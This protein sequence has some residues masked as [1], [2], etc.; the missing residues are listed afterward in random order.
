MKVKFLL[1]LYFVAC[2]YLYSQENIFTISERIGS[3][4]DSTTRVY[5]GLFSKVK[6]FKKA[7]LEKQNEQLRFVIECDSSGK[8][9]TEY[10][11][12]DSQLLDDYKYWVENFETISQV[13]YKD[14]HNYDTNY[15]KNC[16]VT[17]YYINKEKNID[18]ILMD[19]SK[20]HGQLIYSD[21]N[22]V[23]IYKTNELYNWRQ[24]DKLAVCIYY[25]DILKINDLSYDLIGG[26][27]DIF[28]KNRYELNDYVSYTGEISYLH[29]LSPESKNLLK[30]SMEIVK[31]KKFYE[32]LGTFEI[33]EYYQLKMSEKRSLEQISFLT[34]TF[35]KN[36]ISSNSS[37]SCEMVKNFRPTVKYNIDIP[38]IHDFYC[39]AVF[40]LKSIVS[41]GLIYQTNPGSNSNGP[42]LKQLSS[43]SIGVNL[44]LINFVSTLFTSR[45][46][47]LL[48]L[49]FGYNVNFINYTVDWKESVLWDEGGDYNFG[50][51][52]ESKFLNS[53][54]SEI[55][56]KLIYNF[57][58]YKGF[59]G[60]SSVGISYVP[61]Y[62]GVYLNFE[63][64]GRT[65][66]LKSISGTNSSLGY[67]INLG[68]G[69]A[70]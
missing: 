51:N 70:F 27:K 44:Y 22:F 15:F 17:A 37:V 8:S 6:N 16:R 2:S 20:I 50:L 46:F 64:F 21:S 31:N 7:H 12:I 69:Y 5:F 47:S 40:N 10:M 62:G 42:I 43:N 52:K 48:S 11:N 65:Y 34:L 24:F 19:S 41:L 66:K 56:S 39:E 60:S 9:Y 25:K 3:E 45:Y 36:I 61:G 23:L 28:L 58:I 59:I 13:G 49:V 29:L 38:S 67:N 4:I 33:S 57:N 35:G 63:K 26:H 32:P 53:N 1:I 68:I 14:N 54:I 30:K 55:T 18:I